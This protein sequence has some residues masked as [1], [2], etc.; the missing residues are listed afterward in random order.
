VADA[1]RALES[2]GSVFA[3]RE[4][5]W[6]LESATGLSRARFV[7][8]DRALGEDEAR[9]FAGLVARRVAGEPLQYVT[10]VAGFRRL[11]LAV[12][13]GVFIPRPETEVVAERAMQRLPR[14]GR[15][16]DVGTGSGAIALSIA[17][18]MPRTRVWATEL[19]PDA[20]AWAQKNRDAL[21]LD[22]ELV[23]GD[24]FEGLPPELEGRVDVVVANPP[25]VPEKDRAFLPPDVVGHEPRVALFGSDDGLAVIRRIAVGALPWL[26]PRG[27]V[28]LEVGDR[29]GSDVAELLTAAGYRDAAVHRDLTGRE[30]IVEARV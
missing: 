12:G 10:G 16:V 20:F 22:V 8:A 13:P 5:E 9:R 29:Q 27:W 18:E 11:E 21:G 1:V 19:S 4:V 3:R 14:R 28:V 25:Y 6:L 15:V 2:A 23:H 17:D 30:R 26:R 24:L 7:A